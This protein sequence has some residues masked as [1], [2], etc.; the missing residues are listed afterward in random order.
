MV[1]LASSYKSKRVKREVRDRSIDDKNFHVER[2]LCLPELPAK[3]VRVPCHVDVRRL[4]FRNKNP[5]QNQKPPIPTPI[6]MHA[7]SK[8]EDVTPIAIVVPIPS[9][10]LSATPLRFVIYTLYSK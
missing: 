4:C 1:L 5:L 9:A 10:F 6:P 8:G 7:N 3:A 2:M